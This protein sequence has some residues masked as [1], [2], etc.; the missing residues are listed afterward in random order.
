M[1]EGIQSLKDMFGGHF[2]NGITIIKH[3]E[4][5]HVWKRVRMKPYY[6]KRT[7]IWPNDGLQ[8]IEVNGRMS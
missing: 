4:Y 1:V 8:D 5:S 6:G 7:Q 3:W 2:I